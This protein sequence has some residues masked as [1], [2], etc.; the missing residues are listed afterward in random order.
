MIAMIHRVFR[1]CFG[2][3]G[4]TVGC[5]GR[6]R[7]SWLCRGCEEIYATFPVKAT[8]YFHQRCALLG[9]DL[10]MVFLMVWLSQAK[11]AKR[12]KP[13]FIM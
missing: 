8:E 5:L 6:C 10:K 7:N 11:N 4:T 2:E 9:C 1:S 13:K 12:K 3:G